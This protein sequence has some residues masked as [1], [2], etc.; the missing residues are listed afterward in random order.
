MG[1]DP[2]S[3]T[4]SIVES[5]EVLVVCRPKHMIHVSYELTDILNPLTPK[6]D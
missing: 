2:V 4:N 6:S 1:S 3:C 5:F